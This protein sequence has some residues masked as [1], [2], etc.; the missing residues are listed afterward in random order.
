MSLVSG[1]K[2]RANKLRLHLII[3]KPVQALAYNFHKLM[4]RLVDKKWLNMVGSGQY[5]TILEALSSS[6]LRLQLNRAFTQDQCDKL[7]LCRARGALE[8][9][10]GSS[11]AHVG[12]VSVSKLIGAHSSSKRPYRFLV[13]PF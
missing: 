1:S 6:S 11:W 4:S 10:L 9:E 13:V 7:E 2:A 8:L 5:T 12:L 3:H